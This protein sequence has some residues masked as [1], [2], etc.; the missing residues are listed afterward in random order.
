MPTARD[1]ERYRQN[2]QD[3]IDSAARYHAMADVEGRAGVATVY[4]DLAAMEEKHAAFWEHAMAVST[5]TWRRL[6][7]AAR[8]VGGRMRKRSAGRAA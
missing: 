8:P 4:R 3:E 6:A 5:S 2:W 7:L 1:I